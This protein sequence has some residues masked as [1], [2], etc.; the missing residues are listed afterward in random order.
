MLRECEHGVVAVQGW[1]QLTAYNSPLLPSSGFT[2][3]ANTAI[4]PHPPFPPTTTAMPLRFDPEFWAAMGP[5]LSGP[6]P[7]PH[8]TVH[9]LRASS[10]ALLSGYFSSLPYPSTV[11]KSEHPG[12]PVPLTRFTPA[13]ADAS[14][15]QPAVLY[16]HGG[17]MVSQSVEIV[18]PEVAILA[19]QT[20]TTFFAVGYRLAPEHPGPAAAEDTYAAL[21]YLIAHAAE[22]GLDPERIGLYGVSGG[23]APAA[24]AAL[25]ARDRGLTP[26]PAKLILVYPM[27]DDR[28]RLNPESPLHP[29]LVWTPH[30]SAL[31][32]RAVL[33]DKAGDPAAEVSPYA[34][35]GRAVDLAGMPATYVDCGALDLFAGE[36][37]AFAK[38]LVGAGVEVEAHVWPGVPHGFEG[39]AGVSWATRAVEG[40][41]RAIRTLWEV[42]E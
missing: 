25:M 40:R 10:N 24:G 41:V 13:E 42:R 15:P 30:D 37:L 1:K 22:L 32:W 16:V 39:A 38:G 21:S 34:A 33:G 31:A 4:S 20:Q 5:R 28:T 29:F 26:P 19:Q 14:A 6:R 8:E 36:S 9:D 17:G 27:L 3:Q 7:P 2:T 35:P 23:G 18:S 12:A 11:T